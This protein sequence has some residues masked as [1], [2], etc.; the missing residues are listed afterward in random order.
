MANLPTQQNRGN[1]KTDNRGRV[2][3]TEEPMCII[4]LT[5]TFWQ[6][7]G[8]FLAALAL[9]RSHGQQEKLSH[10]HIPATESKSVAG[11]F[12]SKEALAP[13]QSEAV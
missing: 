10:I 9:W 13:P 3:G 2:A 5:H 1:S 11:L 7:S 4:Q 6:C 12:L 8:Q